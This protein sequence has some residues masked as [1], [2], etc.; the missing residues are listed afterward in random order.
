MFA[1]ILMTVTAAATLLNAQ[2]APAQDV[3]KLDRIEQILANLD[4]GLTPAERYQAHKGFYTSAASAYSPGVCSQK[5]LHDRFPKLLPPTGSVQDTATGAN[6]DLKPVL[7]DAVTNLAFLMFAFTAAKDPL[8]QGHSVCVGLNDFGSANAFSYPHGYIMIDPRIIENIRRLPETSKA[9]ELLIYLHEFAHQ[10]Q[11]W[12]DDQF[13]H[14]TTARHME[15]AADCVGAG[16][17]FYLWAQPNHDYGLD[18]RSVVN[19]ATS[20]GDYAYEAG[21]HGTPAERADAASFGLA[22][23]KRYIDSFGSRDGLTATGILNMCNKHVREN[24]DPMFH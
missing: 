3:P 16:L 11:F 23:V 24:K 12:S 15:L 18:E 7:D 8:V 22:Y 21:H 5:A 4:D 1:K 10:L 17:L 2:A 13:M 19:A 6:L 14:E 9:G 20:V